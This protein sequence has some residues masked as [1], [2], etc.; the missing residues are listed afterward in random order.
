MVN[1]L[2]PVQAQA[3]TGMEWIGRN[4]LKHQLVMLRQYG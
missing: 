2:G 3:N 4:W 1:V